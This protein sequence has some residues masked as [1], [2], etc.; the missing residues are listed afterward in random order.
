MPKENV[1]ESKYV[2]CINFIRK[3]TWMRLFVLIMF[4]QEYLLIKILDEASREMQV[5]QVLALEYVIFRY[6]IL[7]AIYF[8]F[9]KDWKSVSHMFMMNKV[10][11]NDSLWRAFLCY[12]RASLVALNEYVIF[13]IAIS[14]NIG[15]DRALGLIVNFGA[16]LIVCELDDIIMST[17]RIQY[18]RELY[19]N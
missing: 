15:E 12:F 11:F 9:T 17:G 5:Y 13:K 14:S 1:T 7:L 19:E 10:Y 4:L 3:F 8:L 16:T 6:V 2:R 18:W